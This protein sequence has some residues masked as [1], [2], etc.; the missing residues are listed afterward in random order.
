M[1]YLIWGISVFCIVKLIVKVMKH[2][3]TNNILDKQ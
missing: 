3:E 1:W 2:Q